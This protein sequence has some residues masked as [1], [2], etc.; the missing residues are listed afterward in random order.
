[1]GKWSLS[2]ATTD[3]HKLMVGARVEYLSKHE[4]LKSHWALI[5]GDAEL[6]DAMKGV[7]EVLSDKEISENFYV[8]SSFNLVVLNL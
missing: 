1:M 3:K 7:A 4:L 8:D 2:L 5:A 6:L